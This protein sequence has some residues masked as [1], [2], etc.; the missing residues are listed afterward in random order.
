M[1]SLL[2]AVSDRFASE[3]DSHEVLTRLYGELERFG[4]TKIELKDQNFD[5]AESCDYHRTDIC[6]LTLDGVINRVNGGHYVFAHGKTDYTWRYLAEIEE[7]VMYG[8]VN[9]GKLLLAKKEALNEYTHPFHNL[10]EKETMSGL[11][12]KQVSLIAYHSLSRDQLIYSWRGKL[13]IRTDFNA[14]SRQ[15][16]T[17]RIPENFIVAEKVPVENKRPIYKKDVVRFLVDHVKEVLSEPNEN[18]SKV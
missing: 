6:M 13:T 15:F 9:W 4:E 2:K 3:L 12:D 14:L 5:L 18:Q 10:P 1:N 7:A 17:R 16:I 11:T 8:K